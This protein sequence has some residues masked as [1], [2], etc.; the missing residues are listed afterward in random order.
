MKVD[1]NYEINFEVLKRIQNTTFEIGDKKDTVLFIVDMNNGFAKQGALYSDRVENIIPNVKDIAQMFID[2]KCPIVAFSDSH[3]E[4]SIE[5]KTY[6]KH[7]MENSIETELVDELLEMKDKIKIISKNSTNGFLEE[8]TQAAIKKFIKEG[9]KNWVIIGC[10]TDICVKFF[11]LTLQNYFTKEN[12]DF[13]IVIPTSAVETYDA[14]GHNAN[15]MNLF[16][17]LEMY[18]NG[19]TVVENII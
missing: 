10:C 11:A 4:D 1:F 6:P 12:L 8:E 9:Y 13:N 18:M 7:C 16:S 15:A 14:P 3:T 17:L 19:I 2:R 5:F